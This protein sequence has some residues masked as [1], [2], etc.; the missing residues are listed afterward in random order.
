MVSENRRCT[1]CGNKS[2]TKFEG[3]FELSTYS[4]R[5][6]KVFTKIIFK[7]SL[8][9]P[10][11]YSQNPVLFNR[12]SVRDIIVMLEESAFEPPLDLKTFMDKFKSGSSR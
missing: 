6:G 5:C 7:S 2:Y 10:T 9:L 3:G 1:N 8:K 11:L 4:C 12:M